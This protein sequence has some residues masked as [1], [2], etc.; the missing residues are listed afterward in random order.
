MNASLRALLSGVIDYA[1]LFPP[2]RLPLDQAI[3]NY[4]RYRQGPD[5]W[6]LGRFVAPVRS[7]DE[8]S[9][10]HDDLFRAGPRLALTVLG[11]PRSDSSGYLVAQKEDYATLLDFRERNGAWA[12]ADVFELQ[13]PPESR[14]AILEAIRA[15]A[16][17][18]DQLATVYVE[19][20]PGRDGRRQILEITAALQTANR[21]NRAEKGEASD[22]AFK[23]RTGGLEASAFPTV[24]HVALVLR[25]C[26]EA[27]LPMKFTAGLHHPLR[28]Y[29]AALQTQ[30]HG[31]INVFVAGVLAHTRRVD[32]EALRA[33]IADEDPAHFAFTDAGLSWKDL[34]ASVDEVAAARHN[35][36]TS[37]GSCSFDEPRDD[38][39]ALGWM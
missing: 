30:M 24:E 21:L 16:L 19:A 33:V 23:F 38:L 18:E 39:R 14:A 9:A 35:F 11:A 10:F 28:H 36:V 32:E 27:G 22:L 31:F 17:C 34:H 7:L 4:A 6:M 25:A 1:G 2:A 20:P 37:F 15:S 13:L 5:A 29:N 12:S 3:R 8:V 26:R